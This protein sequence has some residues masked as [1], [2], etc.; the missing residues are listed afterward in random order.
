[1]RDRA[2]SRF[3][4]DCEPSEHPARTLL[5]TARLVGTLQSRRSGEERVNVRDQS[6]DSS[7]E[8]RK[9]GRAPPVPARMPRPRLLRLPLAAGRH[10][11]PHHREYEHE[12]AKSPT[13]TR[14]PR[15]GWRVAADA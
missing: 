1:M 3:Q 9:L 4:P 10:R 14:I 8:V 5:T 15:L 12:M 13:W 6:L 7:D 2:R 11:R